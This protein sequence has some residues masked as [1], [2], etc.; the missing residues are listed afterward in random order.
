MQATEKVEEGG[1]HC[2]MGKMEREE[3]GQ[4]LIHR[5]REQCDQSNFLLLTGSYSI[6]S[7]EHILCLK[8]K[9]HMSTYSCSFSILFEKPWRKHSIYVCALRCIWMAHSS[10]K[11]SCLLSFYWLTDSDGRHLAACLILKQGINTTYAVK[12]STVRKVW[13]LVNL[14]KKRTQQTYWLGTAKDFDT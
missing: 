14:L 4:G 11:F 9:S 5:Q 6:L 8:S 13:L 1:P 10:K 7:P 12:M 2:T 3:G